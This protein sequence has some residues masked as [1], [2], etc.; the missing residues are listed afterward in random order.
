MIS[1]VGLVAGA[2]ALQT[3][4]TTTTLGKI[5]GFIANIPNAIGSFIAGVPK[6]IAGIFSLAERGTAAVAG[7]IGNGV[8]FGGSAAVGAVAN[9]LQDPQRNDAS[10]SNRR[11]PQQEDET[12]SGTVIDVDGSEVAVVT[13]VT[14]TSPVVL[15]GETIGILNPVT[16][17]AALAAVAVGS[18]IGSIMSSP[19]APN[20]ATNSN[21][22]ILAKG[23]KQ[24]L[25][26]EWVEKARKVAGK[27]KEVACAYLEA[28][29]KTANSADR[30]KIKAAQKYLGCR[31]SSGGGGR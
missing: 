21:T 26:N 16:G 23:G 15:A 9:H 22:N 17:L 12:I 28:A 30:L 14:V 2:A 6:T 27:S 18:L 7:I 24:N 3:F 11:R 19:S 29:Y 13:V 5:L 1:V 25:S 8:L 31:R 4:L 10:N 20:S